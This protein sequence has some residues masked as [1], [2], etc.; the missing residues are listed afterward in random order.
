[1]DEPLSQRSANLNEEL[2]R[3]YFEFIF[4]I[5]SPSISISPVISNPLLMVRIPFSV[6]SVSD[7]KNCSELNPSK[8]FADI[9]SASIKS[10]VTRASI[11]VFALVVV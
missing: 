8:L 10:L 11:S 1:M 4:G 9:S 7:L 3:V 2:P 5:I 6:V